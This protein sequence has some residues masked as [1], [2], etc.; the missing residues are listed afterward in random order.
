MED[1]F[2]SEILPN[3]SIQT[4]VM[5]LLLFST[6]ISVMSVIDRARLNNIVGSNY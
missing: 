6:Y 5:Q 1:M 3:V 2:P 4:L